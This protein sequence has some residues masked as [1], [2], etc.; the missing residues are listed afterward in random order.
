MAAN[1]PGKLLGVMAFWL[2]QAPQA[3]AI[4][5]D[6]FVPDLSF[7]G[8][9]VIE[10]RFAATSNSTSM[11]A[12]RA[13]RLENG[14]IVVAGL[15]HE[16]YSSAVGAPTNVG[17]V[18]YGPG[19]ARTPWSNPTPAYS[20]FFNM[21]VEYPNSVSGTFGAVRDVAAIAGFIFVLAD[22][23]DPFYI[24]ADV[25]VQVLVFGEDGSFVGNY[26]AFNTG[27]YEDGVGLV[28]YLVP[29]C[30]GVISCPMLI[31]VANYREGGVSGNFKIT[32]KRFSMGNSGPP[33]FTPNGT[34]IVDTTFGP[35][36]N[37]ANDYVPT[38]CHD[39]LNGCSLTARAVAAVRT[40]SAN[41]TLYVGA[42]V[43][44]NGQDTA[45]VGIDGGTGV[46]LSDFGIGGFEHFD[47]AT[48]YA[49]Y[50]GRSSDGAVAI[51]ATTF[52]GRGSDE[53]YVVSSVQTGCSYGVGVVKLRGIAGTVDGAFGTGGVAYYGGYDDSVC[54]D[55][56]QGTEPSAVAIQGNR[57]AIAGVQE[58]EF[59][60][61][62]VRASDGVIMDNRTQ[63]PMSGG[64]QWLE[65]DG[66][67]ADIVGNGNG[68]FVL[69]GT[70]L[71]PVNNVGLFG[72]TQIA[73]DRFFAG[74]FE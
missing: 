4:D 27:L 41:P 14:D 7:N 29:N 61:A 23:G 20:H 68:A 51:A 44:D 19:G 37:G 33:S 64:T 9:V 31:A 47:L 65:Y 25:D 28:P 40:N 22:I 18:R 52:V 48:A 17:L 38:D 70:L 58:Y 45:V 72:T 36:G 30:N 11:S 6:P 21:Y 73:S 5:T 26:D 56:P 66:G 16:A 3:Y 13:V 39:S 63:H 49:E 71:D 24:S 34:L 54:P 57:L 32:A 69:T 53:V 10:D 35:Y 67:W 15:V 12:A 59:E 74:T 42:I 43:V 60:V 2:A 8:G 50:N 62:I 1:L 55:Y 46:M